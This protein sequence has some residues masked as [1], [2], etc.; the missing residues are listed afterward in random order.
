MRYDYFEYNWRVLRVIL[1]LICKKNFTLIL[2]VSPWEKGLCAARGIFLPSSFF[3]LRFRNSEPLSRI[4]LARDRRRGGK[5]NPGKEGR[6]EKDAWSS[7]FSSS[8]R[9]RDPRFR[10]SARLSAAGRIS[11]EPRVKGR[12]RGGKKNAEAWAA[13]RDATRHSRVPRSVVRG[14]LAYRVNRNGRPSRR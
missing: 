13:T 3:P 14:P 9:A 12:K 1:I 7:F 11:G 8:P 4:L 5:S 10:A 6:A 2:K